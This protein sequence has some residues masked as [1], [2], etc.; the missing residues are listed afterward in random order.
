MSLTNINAVA[1]MSVF[2]EWFFLDVVLPPIVV[3]LLAIHSHLANRFLRRSH[4]LPSFLASFYLPISFI[5]TYT[6]TDRRRDIERQTDIE[7]KK[8]KQRDRYETKQWFYW[9]LGTQEMV[10]QARRKWS[11]NLAPKTPPPS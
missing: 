10:N 7:R 8:A 11:I 2:L 1:K 5:S 4:F 6:R 3:V 9:L